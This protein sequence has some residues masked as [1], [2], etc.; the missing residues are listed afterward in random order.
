MGTSGE[1]NRCGWENCT[2]NIPIF[3]KMERFSN[4]LII[5]KVKYQV[6]MSAIIRMAVFNKLLIF[7]MVMSMG[8][9]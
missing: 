6:D 5:A 7:K 2:E 3:L 1:R 9:L 8:K 4:K